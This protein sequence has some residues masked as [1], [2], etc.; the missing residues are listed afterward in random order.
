MAHKFHRLFGRDARKPLIKST[1]D[2]SVFSVL[3]SRTAQAGAQFKETGEGNIVAEL[4][5]FMD[6]NTDDK[7]MEEALKCWE[8]HKGCPFPQ[9]SSTLKNHSMESRELT[10]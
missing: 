9:E 5:V 10:R 6:A 3:Q 2:S 1:N 4:D 7:R 8:D